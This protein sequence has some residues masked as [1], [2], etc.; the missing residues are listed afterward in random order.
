MQPTDLTAAVDS[1]NS[2]LRALTLQHPN[3][4]SDVQNAQRGQLYMLREAFTNLGGVA[5][6]SAPAVRTP[7]AARAHRAPQHNQAPLGPRFAA[8][9]VRFAPG[10][11]PFHVRAN[12]QM[13][14]YTIAGVDAT[15]VQHTQVV[16]TMRSGNLIPF[17]FVRGSVDYI[18]AADHN[19]YVINN[20]VVQAGM[21][22]KIP[23][24]WVKKVV[25]A[26]AGQPT[27][28]KED[29]MEDDE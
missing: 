2:A 8:D 19:L 21:Y 5:T 6:P 3:Q 24:T 10:V 13:H 1:I 7:S 17:L 23:Q 12:M 11:H 9:A 29:P 14:P 27:E 22:R 15:A 20:K 28:P 16:H 25:V 26:E 18:V 4:S